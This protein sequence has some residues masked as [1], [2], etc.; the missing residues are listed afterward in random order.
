MGS[1]LSINISEVRGVVKTAI[2]AVELITNYGLEGD[3]H[4]GDWDR[5]VSILP[6]EAIDLLPEN[7][8]QQA[9]NSGFTENF[10]ISGIPLQ[11][12]QPGVHLQIGE[13][14]LEICRVGKEHKEHGRPYVVSREGRFCRVLHGGRV[15]NGDAI[16]IIE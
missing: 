15:Q 12:L 3:A 11:H 14:E 7:R 5:Q 8:R 16:S 4:A 6:I 1:V 9:L 2:P 10:T 13:A